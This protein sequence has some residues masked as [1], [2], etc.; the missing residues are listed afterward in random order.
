MNT[1][2]IKLHIRAAPDAIAAAA[3]KLKPSRVRNC[4]LHI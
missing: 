2:Q 1:V 3:Q 4:A